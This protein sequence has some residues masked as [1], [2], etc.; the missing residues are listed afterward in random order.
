MQALFRLFLKDASS[1]TGLVSR[2]SLPVIGGGRPLPPLAKQT[3]LEMS[4]A[5]AYV[6]PIVQGTSIKKVAFY[7]GAAA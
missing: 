6:P 2:F 1:E 5:K 4:R 7:A 3:F